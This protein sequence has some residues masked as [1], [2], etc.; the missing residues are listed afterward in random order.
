MSKIS[1][2]RSLAESVEADIVPVPGEKVLE[3]DQ[4]MGEARLTPEMERYQ[5]SVAGLCSKI[6]RET[7]EFLEPVFASGGSRD[8]G[9]VKKDMDRAVREVEEVAERAVQIMA[10]EQEKS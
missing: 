3:P 7:D 9:Y 10:R 4:K 1:E 5:K 6:M 2:L 8:L